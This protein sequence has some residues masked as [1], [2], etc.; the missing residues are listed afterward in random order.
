MKS[1]CV[2]TVCNIAY[3]DKALALAESVIEFENKKL[4]IFLFDKK[5]KINCNIDNAELIWIEDIAPKDFYQLAFKYNVIELTTS[6]KPYISIY[7]SQSYENVVFFDPDVMLFSNLNI[8]HDSLLSSNFLLTPHILEVNNDPIINLSFQR[9]GFYNLGFFAFKTS[10]ESLRILEWWW[11]MCKNY[12]FDEVHQGS[13]TDQK[14]M[15][16]A[17]FYFPSISILKNVG[18]NVAWWNLFERTVKVSNDKF[19][20]INSKQ[21][22]NLCFFHF[23][24]F[25]NKDV[26]SKK[27]YSKGSNSEEVLH[28]LCEKY[29]NI[30]E[31]N[32]VEAEKKYSYN[33][34]EN[35]SY[36][37][38]VLR[39]AYAS[40]F[41][42]F[43]DVENPFLN[44]H[45]IN[46][47]IKLNYLKSKSDI[48]LSLIG[49]R[50]KETY[51][52]KIKLFF[53]MMRLILRVIGPNKFMA[54]N[55]LI[56]YSS[57]LI[58]PKHDYWKIKND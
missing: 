42:S 19:I 22:E 36:I 23:S 38:P 15:S 20:V 14:W 32:K 30:L 2:F 29:F 33:Y 16:L 13:F 28:L 35:G 49:H 55:R 46:H 8:I 6:Y 48:D 40:N 18:F 41:D 4:K 34:F 31:K 39:R 52:K 45:K 21:E 47:F 53:S 50:E 26:L 3:L 57:S 54:V 56:T 25:G 9:F 43:N 51:T 7:L 44:N 17:P 10:N 58:L 24:S 1:T 5:R 27:P 12:G 37:N 11:E